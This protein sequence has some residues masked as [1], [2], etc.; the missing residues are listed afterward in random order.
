MRGPQEIAKYIGILQDTLY[1][2]PGQPSIPGYPVSQLSQLPGKAKMTTFYGQ[3]FDPISLVTTI[4]RLPGENVLPV[5]RW[6]FLVHT[7]FP[8][9]YSTRLRIV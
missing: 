7:L 3:R 2:I 5:R 8:A 1:G 9:S 6:E 4:S